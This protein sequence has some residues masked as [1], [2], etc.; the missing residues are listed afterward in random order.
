MAVRASICFP[1]RRRRDYLAVALASVAGQAA[2]RGCE[3]IVVEDDPHDA[4]TAALAAR[5]GA[6]YIAHGAPRGLNAARNTAIDAAAGELVCFLDDDVEV[7]P[8][9][10]DALLAG[11]AAAPEHGVFGGPIRARLEGSRL[12]SCG[13][14]PLPVTTL[15]LG[16]A[17]TDAEFAWGANLTLRRGALELTGRFEEALDLYGDEED[18]QRRF[19]AAGGRVRYVAGAGVDHRRTGR[20]ARVAGLSRSA[21][22]RG[23]NSRR[24]DVRKG[25][26]PSPAAE[27]GTLAGCLWHIV[28]RRCG[29]G[30]VLTALTAGRLAEMLDLAP[31]PPN[32]A[33]PVYLSGRS[34]TLGRRSALAGAVRDARAGLLAL[35]ARARVRHAARRAP[36]RRVHVVGVARAEHL[37]TVARLRAELL[38]SSHDVAL[39]LAP[40]APGAGKWTNINAALAAAP[41]GDADWLLIVDDDV[42]LPRG[43]LDRFLL[44]CERF[45]FELAQ[46]AHAFASHAA[47]DVTRRRP[48]VLAHRTR[49][50]EIGPVTALSARAAAVLLPFPDLRMG[51][52]LDARWSALAAE[53]GWPIGVIDA[54]PVRHLR[55][56]AGDYPRDAAIAEAEAFLD[57]RAYV[58]RVEAAEV[59]EEHRSL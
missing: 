8:G 39:H 45:G 3:L 21:F 28:R 13:R 51:W 34:G 37:R 35:P 1:T 18:W 43:F 12:R 30:I 48:G 5:Y 36:R 46:P 52:G 23:R 2:A 27:L 32:A 44:L 16:A 38:R 7:W 25:V 31:L 17:D 19:K 56:V 53:H 14:E 26:A 6:R 10:L 55:P 58:T 57:G 50:V 49:F 40:P 41:L 42:A 9:W 47:W 33:D 54:T 59:L 15:D 29:T 24:Y 4:Q 20:D 22:L 11:V